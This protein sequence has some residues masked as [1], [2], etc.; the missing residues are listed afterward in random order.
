MKR[1][2]YIDQLKAGM[3]LVSIDKPWLKT[4]FFL[5]FHESR[6]RREK[7]VALLKQYGVREITIDPTR[8]DNIEELQPT[9]L[10][11]FSPPGNE[12]QERT[13]S[14]QDPPYSGSLARELAVARAVRAEAIVTV[15]SLFEGVKTGARID[16]PAVR[17]VVAG[18][19][20]SILRCHEASL[21]L[22][23]MRQFDTNLFTHAVDV[24]VISLVMGKKQGL[25]QQ[26]L[27]FL[28]MGAL[29]HDVGQ[30]RLPRN[31]LRKPGTYTHQEQ[32][33]MQEHL[34]LGV[35]L[36]SQCENI[37]QESRRIV[38]EHHERADGSGYPKGLTGTQISPLS[39]IVGIINVY[40]TMLS[41]YGGAI[42]PTQALRRLYQLG[43][44]RQ[45][46]PAWV[47]RVIRVLGV[48]PVGT[49]VELNTGE[50]GVVI[51]ANPA[52]A[53]RPT[54]KLIW[55]EGQEPYAEPLITDLSAP[56]VSGPQRTVMRALDP[57]REHLDLA[58]Y[59]KKEN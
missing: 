13:K 30:M 6:I 20:D 32:K 49:L 2:I 48:Y 43:T 54:V 22:V 8:G 58:Q 14:P 47:E 50:R 51:A 46:D 19:L 11:A 17:K 25:D 10:S 57:A 1:S 3:Y 34:Q 28:G 21:M 45:F 52:D 33:L 24:C 5:R 4:P 31:L 53:L 23:Q 59:V 38:A 18:L 44:A 40:D 26:Q 12:E 29:L 35:A 9:T 41:S 56:T 16:S 37:S 42:S 27:G 36:L 39:Q 7:E 55:N 15:Q